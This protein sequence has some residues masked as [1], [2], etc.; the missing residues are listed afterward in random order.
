MGGGNSKQRQPRSVIIIFGPP[1]AGK[2]ARDA[3]KTSSSSSR[4][5]MMTTDSEDS[6]ARESETDDDVCATV[7][8]QAPKITDALNIPQLATGDMLRAAVAAGTDVGKKAK[9]A[10]DSG[11]L[12]TDDIVVGIIRDRIRE[13]D[14]ERGFILDGF[15]RTIEQAKKLDEMLKERGESVDV[16][17]SLEVPDALLEERICGRWVHKASGRSYHATFNPP[18]SLIKQKGKQA[19]PKRMFDDVTGEQLE[20]RSDDT[21]EALVARLEA[22]HK[23]TK[24]ILAHY[25]SVV[26]AIDA[27]QEMDTVWK[28][29]DAI[30]PR[31]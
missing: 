1:G 20:Q 23:Q 2:G 21:K 8:T 27:A 26:T 30:L 24:P 28:S 22:Y 12:V 19:K 16:V 10:M 11:G 29:I 31:K 3:K 14:C 4:T 13:K 9:E 6:I 7:G 5:I 18:K 25:E 17:I 15:P